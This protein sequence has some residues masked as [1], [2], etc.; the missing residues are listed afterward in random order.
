MDRRVVAQLLDCIDSVINDSTR[1]SSSSAAANAADADGEE[2]AE[3]ADQKKGFK[4][5]L[6]L[7]AAT[8]RSF[9]LFMSAIKSL[10][11]PYLFL[12]LFLS[13]PISVFIAK[14]CLL[15]M[16]SLKRLSID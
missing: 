16:H 4:G 10:S 13:I 12:S 8:S 6:I 7:I 3:M 5:H 15:S 14:P 2:G 9:I 1:S 11:I